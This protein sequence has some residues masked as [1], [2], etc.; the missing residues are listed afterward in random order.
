MSKALLAG[1]MGGFSNILGAHAQKQHEDE[2]DEK[3]AQMRMREIIMQSPDAT[4]EDKAKAFGEWTDIV[5]GKKPGTGKPKA[6][7][8]M[9]SFKNV[10]G[11]VLTTPTPKGITDPNA[12]ADTGVNFQSGA[13]GGITQRPTGVRFDSTLPEIPKK[14]GAKPAANVNTSLPDLPQRGEAIGG[15]AMNQRQRDKD[16]ARAQA[17]EDDQR[18]FEQQV[19]LEQMKIDAAKAVASGK[20]TR[21]GTKA[22]GRDIPDDTDHFGQPIERSE[23]AQYDMF[24]SGDGTV[25]WV[26]TTDQTASNQEKAI[27][28]KARQIEAA[29]A[30]AGKP[31]KT[32][33]EYIAQARVESRM[34]DIQKRR[35]KLGRYDQFL[36]TA[37]AEVQLTNARTDLDVERL[38][39]LQQ[40]FP[41]TFQLKQLNIDTA[42]AKLDLLG[43]PSPSGLMQWADNQARI[44]ITQDGSPFKGEDFTTVRDGLLKEMGQDP[45]DLQAQIKQRQAPKTG[46]AGGGGGTAPR[47]PLMDDKDVRAKAKALLESAN[48]LAN[49]AAI[50]TFLSKPANLDKVAT[51]VGKKK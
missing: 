39:Q 38:K 2:R 31:R 37:A 42:K 33:Q 45:I 19:K 17:I 40:E 21:T 29:D 18:N 16:A 46:G 22:M 44:L 47:N 15:Y 48:Y 14:K 23:G 13:E 30:A 4:P 34:D 3:T 24:R 50:D 8:P 35:E 5:Q 10:V 7:D 28:E 51:L 32:T 25:T 26:R 9:E 41:Y 6:N 20:L 12:A 36:K 49:D 43:Q 11:R 1:L 27:Q